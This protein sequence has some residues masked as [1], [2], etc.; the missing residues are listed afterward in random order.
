MERLIA[1]AAKL[2]SSIQANDLS[3]SNIVKAIN[4]VQT[5]MGITGT[6]AKEAGATI[7]GSVGAMKSAWANLVTGL[8]DS[9]ADIG[10]LVDNFVVTI[11]GDGTETN[12]G[13]LGNILPA[14]ETALGGAT[15]LIEGIFPKVAKELPKWVGEILPSLANSAVL[16]VES[17]VNSISDN[18]DMLATNAI[19]VVFT[20]ANGVLKLLPKIVK[21]GLDL[22]ISLANGITQAIQEDN[23]IKTIIDVV[24]QI[25]ETLTNPKT[26]ETLI[27]SAFDLI[28]ALTEGLLNDESLTALTDAIFMLIDNLIRFL[29]DEENIS[30]IVDTGVTFALTFW[31]GIWNARWKLFQGI[32]ELALSLMGKIENMDWRTV[33]E[34]IINSLWNG[35]AEVWNN[36]VYWFTNELSWFSDVGDTIS[37]IFGNSSSFGGG[38]N[39]RINGSH[40]SGLNYV[41]FDG[42]IAQ[43]HKGERV[44]TASEA[45]RYNNGQ[46]YGGTTD[47][48][49]T[50]GF[51]NDD[52]GMGLARWLYP[53]IKQ[54]EKEVYA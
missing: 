40:A 52:N 1:D 36:L 9:N 42:Y 2:D 3:F 39:A 28:L 51:D 27:N 12:L 6:T 10:Q 22:I 13:V 25:V 35:I 37:S 45:Q 48:N 47:V 33:G 4:V 19:D 49:V 11:V 21:L 15:K 18:S 32:V 14:V 31:S 20:L 44:L 34:N 54:V 16:I 38:A 7:A 24:G 46:Y 50:V 8:A 43:L 26:L 41:P 23:F 30:K 17:L 5:E 53:K 29:L